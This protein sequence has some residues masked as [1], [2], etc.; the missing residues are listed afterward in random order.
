MELCLVS[1]LARSSCTLQSFFESLHRRF[2]DLAESF[3]RLSVLLRIELTFA[4]QRSD[5]IDP[6]VE[7]QS[8]M[9]KG[10]I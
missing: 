7:Q 10:D 5:I 9:R 6:K 3:R 2:P 4:R 1:P 8:F